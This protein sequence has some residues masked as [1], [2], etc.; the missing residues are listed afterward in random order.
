MLI[1]NFGNKTFNQVV[2][3]MEALGASRLIIT[4]EDDDGRVV[5]L[6]VAAKDDE[7]EAI[8]KRLEAMDDEGQRTLGSEED[9]L[10]DGSDY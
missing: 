10:Y 9:D 3:E 2:E 6:A 4:G 8:Y 7:A 1:E 5:R